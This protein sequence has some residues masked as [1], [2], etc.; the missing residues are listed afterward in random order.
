MG[1]IGYELIVLGFVCIM[2]KAEWLI[3]V[4]KYL[5]LIF[6]TAGLGLITITLW[7]N[8]PSLSIL[9]GILMIICLSLLIW[10]FFTRNQQIEEVLHI[11]AESY[12]IKTVD[13]TGTPAIQLH[14]LLIYHGKTYILSTMPPEGKPAL[15]LHTRTQKH[16]NTVTADIAVD[17]A[18]KSVTP[19]QIL[20]LLYGILVLMA[21]LFIPVSYVMYENYYLSQNFMPNC[22][23]ITLGY[24]TASATRGNK[25]MLYRLIHWF[26]VFLEA[27]GW[28]TIVIGIW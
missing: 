20:Y 23:M 2:A 25:S 11:P 8:E 7:N 14:Y 22:I 24:L 1:I 18:D 28:I 26:A 12:E 3:P 4:R 19:K 9:F 21:A 6:L 10:V 15:I 13:R 27:A 17:T 5:M 16:S